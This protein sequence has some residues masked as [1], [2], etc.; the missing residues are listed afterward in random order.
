MEIKTC[1]VVG[2]G[3]MGNGIAQVATQVGGLN[4]IMNDIGDEFVERGLGVITK[5]LDRL[6]SK[7]RLTAAQKDDIL[8]RIKKSTNI[9]DMK[10]ADFVVEAATE[11]V[12]PHYKNCRSDKK[13]GIGHWYAFLQPCPCYEGSGNY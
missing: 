12:Y 3:T 6:M 1:G 11:K 9:E 13:A 8:G 4:V 2:A 5:N 7:E 10:D